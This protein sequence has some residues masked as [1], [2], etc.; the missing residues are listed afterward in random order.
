MKVHVPQTQQK[1]KPDLY[2]GSTNLYAKCQ[3][4]ISKDN[5]EKSGN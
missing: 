3:V 1:Q 2:Y 4:N 5:R